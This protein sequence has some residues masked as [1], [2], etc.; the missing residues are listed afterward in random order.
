M[1]GSGGRRKR[2]KKRRVIIRLSEY[3]ENIKRKAIIEIINQEDH[4]L[5]KHITTDSTLKLKEYDFKKQ[6]GPRH[7]WWL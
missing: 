4:E 7:H 5:T 1:H 6:Y 2:K 3:Y